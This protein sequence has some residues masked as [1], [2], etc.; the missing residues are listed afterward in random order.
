VAVEHDAVGPAACALLDGDTT[1]VDVPSNIDIEI[2]RGPLLEV[3]R[4]GRIT[5]L[6]R[7][8]EPDGNYEGMRK[9]RRYIAKLVL[10]AGKLICE[11]SVKAL[12]LRRAQDRRRL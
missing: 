1:E 4:I 5:V 9:M 7:G 12:V 11:I 3:L 2:K 6:M 8:T 10:V